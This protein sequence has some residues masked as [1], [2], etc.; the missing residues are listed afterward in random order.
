MERG[1]ASGYDA[2][3]ERGSKAGCRALVRFPSSSYPSRRSHAMLADMVKIKVKLR[4]ASMMGNAEHSMS[5]SVIMVIAAIAV[6]AK[7]P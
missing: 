2:A 3:F 7:E 5:T 4:E 1:P 6:A